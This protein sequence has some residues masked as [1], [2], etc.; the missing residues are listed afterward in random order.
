[1]KLCEMDCRYEKR[2]DEY[3]SALCALGGDRAGTEH[4]AARWYQP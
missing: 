2:S 4:S 1:M 3:V